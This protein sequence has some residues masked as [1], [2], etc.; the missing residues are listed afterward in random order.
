MAVKGVKEVLNN[1]KSFEI[2]VQREAKELIRLYTSL[3]ENEAI[4]NAPG[5]NDIIPTQNGTQKVDVNI[6]SFIFSKIINQGYTGVIGL[7]SNA[8]LLAVYIE[9]GTG[10]S[11]AGY[12]PTLPKEFQEIARTYFING[13]GTLIK[14]PFLLPAYFQYQ[15]DFIKDFTNFLDEKGIKYSKK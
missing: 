7:E 10:A 12:V 4:R 9:F 5:A 15:D 11:A 1:L 6:P 13:K 2:E 3:I 14:K 8:S